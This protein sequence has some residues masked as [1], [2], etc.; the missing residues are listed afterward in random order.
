MEAILWNGFCQLTHH[1]LNRVELVYSRDPLSRYLG[2]EPRTIVLKPIFM[3]S[4]VEQVVLT[5]MMDSMNQS[6]HPALKIPC[7]KKKCIS[8]ALY[9]TTE[10]SIKGTASAPVASRQ[11]SASRVNQ[12]KCSKSSLD[13][14]SSAIDNVHRDTPSYDFR[15]SGEYENNQF[16]S[17]WSLESQAQLGKMVARVPNW[18][19]TATCARTCLR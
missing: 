13:G 4:L 19:V 6:I 11:D 8:V 16:S 9:I 5:N 14:S 7:E 2:K 12:Y 10:Q 17:T 1:L 18:R 3:H 15:F